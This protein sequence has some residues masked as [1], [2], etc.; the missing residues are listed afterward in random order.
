[1]NITNITEGATYNLT[2]LTTVDAVNH[3]DLL[4]FNL[5]SLFNDLLVITLLWVTM[6]ILFMIIRSQDNVKDTEAASYA[7]VIVSVGSIL[8]LFIN[9]EG[10]SLVSF[11][12]VFPLWVITG[13]AILMDKILGNY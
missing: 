7:G 8:I 5:N 1:M 3:P 6:I 4:I 9:I 10:S 2:K 13:L 12:Q 11:A